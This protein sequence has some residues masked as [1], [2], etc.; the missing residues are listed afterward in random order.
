MAEQSDKESKTEEATEK[1]VR[2]SIEKGQVP[3]A[4]EVSVVGSFLA[5]LVFMVFLAE[6]RAVELGAFLSMFL[7][8]PEAWTLS[9]EQDAA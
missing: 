3:F 2:D 8:R 4:K 5:I 7:E 1:K 6:P 9:T